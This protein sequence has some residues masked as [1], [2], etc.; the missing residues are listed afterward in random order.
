VARVLDLDAARAARSEA[1]GEAP[2]ILFGGT[3][4]DLPVELPWEI[5]EA[6]AAGDGAG[7]LRA[8]EL[9]LGD[10][11]AEFKALKPSLADVMVIVEGLGEIYGV[12]PGN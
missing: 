1:Q 2:S 12:S 10:R 7:A 9:L 8:I 3:T 4:F 6:A 5:A 11:W